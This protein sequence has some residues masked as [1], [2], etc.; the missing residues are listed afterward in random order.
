MSSKV[1]S[2]KRVIIDDDV[3]TQYH[4][5]T[6]TPYWKVYAELTNP[7]HLHNETLVLMEE[8]INSALMDGG[9]G[10]NDVLDLVHPEHPDCQYLLK[11]LLVVMTPAMADNI[12]ERC[13]ETA[14]AIIDAEDK[15][16]EAF[17]ELFWN[18]VA[19]A[20]ADTLVQLPEHYSPRVFEVLLNPKGIGVLMLEVRFFHG[21]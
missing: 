13:A 11:E 12:S 21:E 9:L 8:Q 20:I 5:L 6:S 7:N 18:V 10:I 3:Y 14:K 17:V 1:N 19:D 16:Y 4:D 2:V 15:K